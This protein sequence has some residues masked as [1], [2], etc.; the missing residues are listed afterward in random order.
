MSN[1]DKQLERRF[2]CA[3]IRAD[4]SGKLTGY[5]SVFNSVSD[6]LGGFREVVRPGAFSRTIKNGSDVRALW[7]H[8]P[9]FVLGRTKSGTLTLAEDAHGLH[10]E[11]DPPACQWANDLMESIRRGDVS[12]MSFG[13]YVIQDGWVQDP[14]DNTKTIRELREVQLFDVS[15]VTYPAYP[16]TE[17]SARALQIVSGITN[18]KELDRIKEFL[19]EIRKQDSETKENPAKDFADGDNNLVQQTETASDPRQETHSATESLRKR[20]ELKEKTF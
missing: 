6:D 1:K 9:N 11:I 13:F 8:D 14:D 2:H 15:P 3:E 4:E 5:A 10:V 17:I 12:Q 20:L 7:N 18:E 16:D 19:T